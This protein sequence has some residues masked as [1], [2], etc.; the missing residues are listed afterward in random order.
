MDVLM[1]LGPALATLLLMAAAVGWGADS[2][3]G[4]SDDHAR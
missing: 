2:R 4:M 1:I 3:D